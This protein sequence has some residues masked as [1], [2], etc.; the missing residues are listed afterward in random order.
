M[1]ILSARE[2]NCN[3]KVTVQQT[4]KMNFTDETAKA[5]AL[6]AKK[7]VKFFMEGEPEQL[8]M[9]I[10]EEPDEDSFQIRKSGAYYYVPAQ[11][12]FDNLGVD[13][14]TY[15]VIYNLVRCP[16]YDSEV[17]GRSYKMNYRPIKKK[18]NEDENIEE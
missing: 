16:A 11:L 1:K 10:V 17:G 6:T 3:L 5:L 13:Y 9:A 2:F 12:L 4:G 7:G 14:K 18:Q 15:T 8:H